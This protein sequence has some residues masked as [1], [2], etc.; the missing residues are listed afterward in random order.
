LK[1]RRLMQTGKLTEDWKTPI[2]QVVKEGP[3]CVA[4][5]APSFKAVR[6]PTTYMNTF[7]M[8]LLL[9][10]L[11]LLVDDDDVLMFLQYLVVFTERSDRK[12]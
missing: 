3:S 1:V 9:L 4:G 8:L 6:W 7:S 11:L 10:L 2:W 12:K 5:S